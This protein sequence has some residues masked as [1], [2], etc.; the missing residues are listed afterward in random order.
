MHEKI[1]QKKRDLEDKKLQKED[2]ERQKKMKEEEEQE[3]KA[4]KDA[5]KISIIQPKIKAESYE[6]TDID[7]IDP[8]EDN[9]SKILQ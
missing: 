3:T 7:L 6:I 1:Q 8:M 2:E 9:P 4:R 5:T